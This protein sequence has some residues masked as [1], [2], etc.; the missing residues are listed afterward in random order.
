MKGRGE[1]GEPSLTDAPA[2]MRCATARMTCTTKPPRLL[3]LVEIPKGSRNKYEWDEELQAITLDR[4]LFS[5]V[6]YPTDYGFVPD[7]LAEDG[8]PLDAMVVVSEPPSRLRHRG[9]ADRRVQDARRQGRRRQDPV[10]SAQRPELE[11][12]GDPRRPPSRCWTRSP[13]SS[14]FTS[15]RRARWSR[16]TAGRP[17]HRPADHRRGAHA[18][19]RPAA[20]LTSADLG[21]GVQR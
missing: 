6:V 21:L 10:R 9:Q 12:D 4:F 14:R 19:A 3:C 15:H 13:T 8:D 5:S 17:R 20:A 2:G 16:S 11:H 1:H 18:G 7:T